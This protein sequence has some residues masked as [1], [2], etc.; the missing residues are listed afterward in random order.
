VLIVVAV[1]WAA[2]ASRRLS[3]SSERDWRRHAPL[4]TRRR[5]GAGEGAAGFPLTSAVDSSIFRD[6]AK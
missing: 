1:P 2:E 5:S 3:K 4:V 6:E